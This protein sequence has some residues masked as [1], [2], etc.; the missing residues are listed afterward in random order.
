MPSALVTGG[1]DGIGKQVARGLAS[2]GH[3]VIVVGRDF[4]KGRRAEG[5]L[6]EA[7]G[8]ADVTFIQG[9]LS[10]VR[11]AARLAEEV[12]ALEP[13]LHYLVH[14]AGFVRGRYVLTD[15]GVESNFA[16][17]YV[18]RFALTKCLLPLLHAS[19]RVGAS[20]RIV[21]L[22]GAAQRG[23]I[24]FED[25]NQTKGFGLI[26]A[27]AQFCQAN[28]VFTME[29]ARRLSESG[30]GARVSITCLKVG[31]VKTGIRREFPTWMKVLVPLVM[32]PFFANTPVKVASC[33]LELLLGAPY[34]GVTGRHF[35]MIKRFKPVT[36]N[37]M[38]RDPKTG[39]R[40]WELSE[41]IVA[42]ASAT[43]PRPRATVHA[44][45]STPSPVPSASG[46]LEG[47]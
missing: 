47:G 13:S 2:S 20:S 41:R 29:L 36:A 9:D 31:V 40:L 10:L 1:T 39:R 3:R 11:G 46:G 24:L 44:A 6:R 43:H 7:S 32:D 4:E 42:S 33:A 28:D 27:I 18:G 8:N 23:R 30:D 37:A 19:G 12:A 5:E 45:R 38:T 16:V 14:G 21:V 34:E 22:G 26:R 17:N 35:L 25:P 15:E